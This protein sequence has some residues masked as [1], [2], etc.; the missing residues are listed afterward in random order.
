MGNCREKSTVAEEIVLLPGAK[1]VTQTQTATTSTLTTPTP[2]FLMEPNTA[3]SINYTSGANYIG[4]VFEQKPN[5]SGVLEFQNHRFQGSFVNGMPNGTL[6]IAI[7][8]NKFYE[9]PLVNGIPHGIGNY[10]LGD[11]VYNGDIANGVCHGMGYCRWGDGTEYE[12]KFEDGLPN[13]NGLMRY[14]DGVVYIGRFLNGKKHG[15]GNFMGP[16]SMSLD[17]NFNEGQL[18]TDEVAINVRGRKFLASVANG[19]IVVK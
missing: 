3:Q 5:G 17:V 13:G 16:N 4:E 14:T 18:L 7:D 1:T 19:Q 11:M 12:G 6:T 15:P 9:G 8:G 2:A 10:H